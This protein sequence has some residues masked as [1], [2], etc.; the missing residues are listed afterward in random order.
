[1]AEFLIS[2]P[3]IILDRKDESD[4]SCLHMACWGT[5]GS[6]TI[7]KDKQKTLDSLHEIIPILISRGMDIYDVDRDG[8]NA[9]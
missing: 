5:F 4:R 8:N 7:K 9:I 6:R 1:M 2:L 3:N